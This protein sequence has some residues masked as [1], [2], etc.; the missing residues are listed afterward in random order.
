LSIFAQNVSFYAGR[1]RNGALQD[2]GQYFGRKVKKSLP[3]L[4]TTS[5]PGA[6]PTT[7][8]LTTATTAL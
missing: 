8:Q 7:F 4:V 5:I 1:Y 2:N 6:N 3:L